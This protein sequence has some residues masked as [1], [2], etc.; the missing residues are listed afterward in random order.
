MPDTA[1]K[2]VMILFLDRFADWE[3][4][5]ISGIGGDFYGLTVRH[6]TPGGGA[7]RSMGGLSVTGLEDA[8]PR[9]D[10]V[11]VLC[12]GE[13]WTRD[14][15]PELGEMLRAAHGRGQT[16]AGICAAT[17]ALGRAGLLDGREHTSNGLDFLR[18][19]L[20]GYAATGH[21]RDVPHAVADGGII[22]APGTAPV[23]FA[24]EVLRAAGLP[25]D[26]LDEFLAIASAEVRR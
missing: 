23:T 11:I 1:L 5:L 12:G 21:Y 14:Q 17:L 7:I 8:V 25:P 2:P 26:K 24:A 16:V 18:H 13:S 3:T 4:P 10:E 19:W 20:P 6:V 9:E 22:T 15:A